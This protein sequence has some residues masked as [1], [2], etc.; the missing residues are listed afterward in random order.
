MGKVL[1]AIAAIAVL[2][3]GQVHAGPLAPAPE[4]IAEYVWNGTEHGTFTHLEEIVAVKK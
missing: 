1:A 2:G 3:A 4:I